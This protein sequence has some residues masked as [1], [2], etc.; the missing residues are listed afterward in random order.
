MKILKETGIDWRVR[1]FIGKAY[2]D[3][4]V[5]VRLNQKEKKYEDWKRI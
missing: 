3:Q 2:T 5:Q 4:S 1:K